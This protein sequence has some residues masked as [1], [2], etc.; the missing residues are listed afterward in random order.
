MFKFNN[1]PSARQCAKD[2]VLHASL[3]TYINLKHAI[4]ITPLRTI[5]TVFI[6]DNKI[7]LFIYLFLICSSLICAPELELVET[8]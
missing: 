2:I 1:M 6:N 7:Y 8:D 3:R 4:P 5:H